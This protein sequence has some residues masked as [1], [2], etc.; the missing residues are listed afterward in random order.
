[1]TTPIKIDRELRLI[2]LNSLKQ[3]FI[4][5]DDAMTLKRAMSDDDNMSKDEIIAELEQINKGMGLVT[6]KNV[7]C[8]NLVRRYEST[9]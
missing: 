8:K 4:P 5:P 6:C 2:M 9:D 7:N 3:G 1:M